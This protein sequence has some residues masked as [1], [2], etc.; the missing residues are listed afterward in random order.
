MC[1]AGTATP[2]HDFGKDQAVTGL[3]DRRV[4]VTGAGVSGRS[5]AEALLAAGASVIVTDASEERLAALA[6]LRAQGAELIA[7]LLEPPEGIEL[8]VTSPG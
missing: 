2:T 3:R 6:S 5:A 1:S 7:G 8:V 4:L